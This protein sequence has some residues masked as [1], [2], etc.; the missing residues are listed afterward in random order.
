MSGTSG[1]AMAEDWCELDTGGAAAHTS[2][3]QGASFPA[4]N[5]E[6]SASHT[7]THTHI[8][9]HIHIH[10]H[11][12]THTHEGI[13]FVNKIVSDHRTGCHG[14]RCYLLYCGLM[15]LSGTSPWR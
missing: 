6:R 1:E 4:R 2:R 12:H 5:T 10:T 7:H 9:T 15:L 3:R 13:R 11:V 8:H 14:R